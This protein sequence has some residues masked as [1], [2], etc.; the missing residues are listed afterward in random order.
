MLLAGVLSGIEAL[1]TM[2]PAVLHLPRGVMAA[3]VP[4]V[5]GAALVSRLVAQ[6]DLPDSKE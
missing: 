4:V 3:V 5:I 6:R 2:F 1:V